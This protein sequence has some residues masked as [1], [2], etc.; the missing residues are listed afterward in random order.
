M[1]CKF[2]KLSIKLL[3]YPHGEIHTT[4][5]MNDFKHVCIMIICRGLFGTVDIY[6][7]ISVSDALDAGYSVTK[8]FRANVKNMDK[9]LFKSQSSIIR[10]QIIYKIN[11][12][13]QKNKKHNTIALHKYKINPERTTTLLT[14][15]H[16][17]NEIFKRNMDDISPKRNK[18]YL[19]TTAI[20]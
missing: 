11:I 3:I 9:I 14:S 20:K 13:D 12:L 7:I 5:N 17:L 2:T 10:I 1:H 6:R 18:S 16:Y 8:L 19:I 15:F 4:P